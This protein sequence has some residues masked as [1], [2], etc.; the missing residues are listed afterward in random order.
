MSGETVIFLVLAILG[1]G[2]GAFFDKISLRHLDPAGAFFAR[3]LVMVVLF[4]PVLIWKS[5]Q[6]KQALLGSDRLGPVF[7]GLSVIV[8]MSA[9]LFFLKALSEGQATRI[10]PLSSTYPFVTF[11]LALAF[12]GESFTLNKF[13]GTLLLSGGVYFISR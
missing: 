10:V 8:S 6:T 11:V 12:L 3:L 13:L 9:V 5:P 1:F 2:L 4:V 7:V